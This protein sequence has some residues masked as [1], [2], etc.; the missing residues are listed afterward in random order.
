[1]GLTRPTAAQIN[2][3]ITTI[4]DPITVLNQGSTLA[5]IDVG[6]IINRNGG[7]L[8]N[9]AI[10]WNE[11]ANTFVT[12]FTT[13]SGGTNANISISTYANLRVNT[14]NS[15]FVNATGN[16][17]AGGNVTATYFTGSGQF[18]TGL[19][20]SYS[21]VNVKAYTESMGFANYSNVNVAAYTQT[22]SY[23]NYSN[24][25]LAAYLGGAVTV[26]GN[27]TVSGNLI[28]QG[29]TTT[30]NSTTLDV[31]DLNI[32]V[33]KDAATA[34]A[35]NGAG[36]TVDG[37]G[38][39]L[40]YT[41]S[42]DSWNI[43]KTFISNSFIN[44][45]ANISTAQLNAGQFNTAGNIL[46]AGA[47]FN[48][49]RVN[50][51]STVNVLNSTGNILGTGGILNS[52][53][54]NGGITSTGFFNTTANISG[55]IVL[56]GTLTTTGTLTAGQINTAGN[57][58]ATAGTFNA[59]TV[60]GNETVTGF[61]NV[62]GNVLAASFV[63]SGALLT[64]LPGYAYS[65]VNVNAYT[66]SMGFQ[67]YSNVNVKAYTESMGFQ[68]YGNV[69]VAALITTN[70]LTNYSNVNLIAYLA[71]GITSTGF[72]NTSGNVSAA[73]INSATAVVTGSTYVGELFVR[74]V[75]GDEGGQLNLAPAVTNTTLVGNVTI[76]VYQN[77]LR[78][79]EGGGTNRGGYF[80]L[81]GLGAS[82]GTNLAAG[83]GG[84]T[85][86]GTQGQIQFNSSS[87]FQG[88]VSL[89][90]FAANG[91]IVANAGI[92]S[93]STTTGTMQITGGIG[94][95]GNVTA[96]LFNSVNNGSGTNFKVG[97]D[98]WL[99]DINIAN[100]LGI[101]GQ[102]DGT[103]G[104]IRFGNVNTNALG[105]SGSGPLSWGGALNVSGNILATGGVFNALTVNGATTQ[106]GTLT[107]SSGFINSTGNILS[108]G[109]IHNALT[110]NGNIFIASF[111]NI[112]IGTQ[113]TPHA[114]AP[115]D[116]SIAANSYVQI[117]IQ[118]IDSVGTLNSADFIA[119][120]PNGT[121]T[122]NFID[123]GIN[124]NNF[125][126]SAWTISGRND[127]YV[128]ID[129]GN[130][131]LGTATAGK[132]VRIHSGGLLSTN[133]VAEVYA[134]NI[135]M[136]GNINPSVSNVYNLG[137]TTLR[138][139]RVWGVAVN[140][141]YADLAENYTS[142]ADY[143]PGTV[144]VFGGGAEVTQSTASHDPRIAG[145]VSTNPAYLMNGAVPGI[146]VALQGRV[147]CQVL[148]PVAKG[149]RLVA[150]QHPGVAQRLNKD[151]YEP[152]CIIGKAL[153]AIETTTIST[154]EVVVGRL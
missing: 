154:I 52:L 133:L 9:T 119:T 41:S 132:T 128:Y 95:T 54:V 73:Q 152:G 130:L 113:L 127:G 101:K 56:A 25:N 38:A 65:N 67:N 131:T 145:V 23:T 71:G 60:N 150:S 97:D 1:M 64:T 99:G 48:S 31:T 121:D 82:V 33:A 87:T 115:L 72:I 117:N 28:V 81:S 3:V 75:G 36:L 105:V 107:V 20:A 80:D 126:S 53:T 30:L 46:A 102:Q 34:A 15:T 42:T 27:L 125:V 68:N 11:S 108:T 124:G 58:L 137:T 69:N 63:G 123:M 110:V 12:A 90:Y 44:T 17:I 43:N 118:N 144:L 7:A 151:L 16:I 149:D 153:Q 37:A 77:K 114:N 47:V 49:E 116:V 21:N 96:D 112:Q 26:G 39:T 129:G 32:T 122:T 51:T 70:G 76:D 134:A 94:V 57:V 61:L 98:V 142:D 148:G 59:L 135:T 66:E 22:Q 93:T 78:I 74:S 10:F 83:G 106:A 29:T 136:I 8:A 104:Y 2:T 120:A 138:W 109:A 50:G 35:A 146:P 86:G 5:N 6:F 88:A 18:L 13:A 45:T 92:S 141:Q 100:T 89:Y 84:G 111:G 62:T 143:A 4:S 14:L 139:N 103:Q 55:A 140:A 147:P 85:P 79:W 91:A 40:L 24:V 19:P